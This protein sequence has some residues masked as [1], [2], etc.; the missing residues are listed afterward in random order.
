MWVLHLQQRL[1]QVVTPFWSEKKGE[2]REERLKNVLE[3]KKTWT[4]AK[5]KQKE[6]FNISKRHFGKTAARFEG[7]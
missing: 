5:K 2:E 4:E 7:D 3:L 1:L 6:N